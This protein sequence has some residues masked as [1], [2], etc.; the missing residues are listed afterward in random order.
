MSCELKF[1]VDLEKHGERGSYAP[2][3]RKVLLH[4]Q[5]CKRKRW[6]R[7]ENVRGEERR[8]QIKGNA[9]GRCGGGKGE[10][11]EQK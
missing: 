2:S 11:T 8:R 9:R 5:V 10:C 1:D 6:R 7:K 3:L 4:Y